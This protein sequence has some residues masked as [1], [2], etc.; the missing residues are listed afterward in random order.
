MQ[1]DSA[2]SWVTYGRV[3][4]KC[5]SYWC[6]ESCG[7]REGGASGIVLLDTGCALTRFLQGKTTDAFLSGNF[8]IF[9]QK[10]LLQTYPPSPFFSTKQ[11][12][13]NHSKNVN[14]ITCSSAPGIKCHTTSCPCV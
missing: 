12:N 1:S 11:V 8:G 14:K 5:R 13:L 9:P 2:A 7:K 4:Q 6:K 3:S 10:M